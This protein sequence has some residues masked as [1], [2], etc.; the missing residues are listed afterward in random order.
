MKKKIIISVILAF[1]V[2]SVVGQLEMI[3]AYNCQDVP[4]FH[5]F[6][7]KQIKGCLEDEDSRLDNRMDVSDSVF[8]FKI[9]ELEN[10][11]DNITRSLN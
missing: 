4:S 7:L 6:Y 3:L 9:A 8:T 11:I 5:I 2:G 1:M 10:R